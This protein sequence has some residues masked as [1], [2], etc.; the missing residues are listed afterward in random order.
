MFFVW[1]IYNDR[2]HPILHLK[3]KAEREGKVV[4]DVNALIHD[5]NELYRSFT[6]MRTLLNP[7][8]TTNTNNTD[9]NT[10]SSG[11]SNSNSNPIGSNSGRFSSFNSR[12]SSVMF[13]ILDNNS[14]KVMPTARPE[15]I[16]DSLVNS[17]QSCGNKFTLTNRKVI[18]ISIYQY[19][20]PFSFS[21]SLLSI[22]SASL[23]ILRK[24]FRFKGSWII[25][26]TLPTTYTYLCCHSF[27]LF[28]CCISP[29]IH[30]SIYLSLVHLLSVS[31]AVPR[32]PSQIWTTL[33]PK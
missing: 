18:I 23:P 7:T 8:Q 6:N 2:I 22:Y 20:S 3:R 26:Y 24:G 16:A 4:G 9:S 11:N 28:L 19:T 27:S 30:R 33:R 13:G 31:V 15:W 32:F 10:N 25:L 29:S 21:Y 14:N 12:R 5:Q 17:C 1:V